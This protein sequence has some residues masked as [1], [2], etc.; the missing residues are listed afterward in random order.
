[1]QV[2]FRQNTFFKCFWRAKIHV[3]YFMA[4]DTLV[5][6]L[7]VSK[8]KTLIKKV[9]NTS[10]ETLGSFIYTEPNHPWMLPIFGNCTKSRSQGQ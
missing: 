3:S 2:M 9:I 10:R 7:W 8:P 5:L 4:T 1:M 6:Y